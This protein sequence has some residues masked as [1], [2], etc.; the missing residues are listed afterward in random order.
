MLP[1]RDFGTGQPQDSPKSD[2]TKKS[3]SE[4]AKV[5]DQRLQGNLS[6]LAGRAS[7]QTLD[8]PLTTITSVEV[9][10]AATELIRFPFCTQ[11]TPPHRLLALADLK[12]ADQFE[13]CSFPRDFPTRRLRLHRSPVLPALMCLDAPVI[14]RPRDKENEGHSEVGRRT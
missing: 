9:T 2:S 8:A 6:E 1:V 3:I 5:E 13:Q 12:P 14:S 10:M 7:A 11:A 4:R